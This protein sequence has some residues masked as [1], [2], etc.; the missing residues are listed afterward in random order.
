MYGNLHAQDPHPARGRRSKA[1]L[2][3]S[4]GITM[5][6]LTEQK[7]NLVGAIGSLFSGVS[8]QV[9]THEMNEFHLKLTAV[10]AIIQAASHLPLR[11]GVDRQIDRGCHQRPRPEPPGS[12]RIRDGVS[13]RSDPAF[14]FPL[15]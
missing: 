5:G 12:Q 10:H 1:A 3:L 4:P 14:W 8:G 7:R 2:D 9:L 13:D 6:Y 11:T 15:P